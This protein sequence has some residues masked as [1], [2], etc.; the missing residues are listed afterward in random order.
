MTWLQMG[1]C[2][3]NNKEVLFKKVV[4][5]CDSPLERGGGVCLCTRKNA[6]EHTPAN[7]QSGAP[8]LERGKNDEG[9]S[10]Y[11]GH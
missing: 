4:G 1:G 8:P 11:L 7:A 3:L 6:V 9:T 2:G 5:L 10:L